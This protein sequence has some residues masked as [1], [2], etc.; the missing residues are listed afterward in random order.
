[1]RQLHCLGVSHVF[2]R[3]CFFHLTWVGGH[4]TVNVGPD[5]Q[6]GSVDGTSENCSRIVGAATAECNSLV[7]VGA[8]NESCCHKQ[9]VSI[10]DFFLNEFVGFL[11]VDLCRTKRFVC[12]DYRA[13]IK[14]F[15]VYATLSDSFCDDVC[16]KTFA[17][18][19][20][21]VQRARSKFAD[22]RNTC[23]NILKFRKDIVGV[24]LAVV[25]VTTRQ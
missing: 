4:H 7:V 5:F 14:K 8:G 18:A 1:M 17:H 10:I 2:K 25:F 12:F 9:C 13:C 15:A 6:D 21:Q 23:E 19:G 3:V 11:K 16:R 22:K 20:N 24:L